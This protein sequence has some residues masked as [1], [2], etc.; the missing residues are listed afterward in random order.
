MSTFNM[1]AQWT[2]VASNI[3]QKVA[4]LFNH[5]LPCKDCRVELLT[6]ARTKGRMTR[7]ERQ[8]ISS[9]LK[10]TLTGTSAVL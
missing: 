8:I 1:V 3:K 7:A 4:R 5:S 9:L 10:T 2:H 6:G